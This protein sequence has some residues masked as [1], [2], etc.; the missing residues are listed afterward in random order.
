[1]TECKV[2]AQ[3]ELEELISELFDDPFASGVI[4][5]PGFDFECRNPEELVSALMQDA[6]VSRMC[7]LEASAIATP[8]K[9]QALRQ[10]A[11]LKE[12]DGNSTSSTAKRNS[13]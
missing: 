2:C 11:A 5:L 12:H 9:A 1:M 4:N 10:L 6:A 7:S 3:I 8:E 13:D